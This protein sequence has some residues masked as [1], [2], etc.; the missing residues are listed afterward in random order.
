M[1]NLVWLTR[2]YVGDYCCPL[3]K[4]SCAAG[5]KRRAF[6]VSDMGPGNSDMVGNKTWSLPYGVKSPGVNFYRIT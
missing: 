4:L 3:T 1:T 5:T 6:L 2:N